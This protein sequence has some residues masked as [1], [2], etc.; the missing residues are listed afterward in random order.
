MKYFTVNP[1]SLSTKSCDPV[2]WNSSLLVIPVLVTTQ[3]FLTINRSRY[4][5]SDF[6]FPHTCGI[7]SARAKSD[8]AATDVLWTFI[9]VTFRSNDRF[10][11]TNLR[12]PKDFPGP[13]R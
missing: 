5:I 12:F 13:V 6:Q 1:G 9:F 4:Q 7:E 2:K 11:T 8:K 10:Q 3:T